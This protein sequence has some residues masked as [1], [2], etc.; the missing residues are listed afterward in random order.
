MKTTIGIDVSKTHLDARRLPDGASSRFT[1]DRRGVRVLIAWCAR[2]EIERVVYE[3]TGA[4]HRILEEMLLAADLPLVKVN[5]LQARRFAQACGTRAKTD[6]VD[7]ALLAR[8]GVA[9][10]PATLSAPPENRG[11]FKALDRPPG[12]D[13]RQD[14]REKPHKDPAGAAA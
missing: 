13:Q 7:A 2:L 14:R 6:A 8:M 12:P 5:P 1:N 4:Y 9:L 11:E 3:P 10:Q